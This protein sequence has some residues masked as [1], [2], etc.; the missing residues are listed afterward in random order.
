MAER[1]DEIF[2]RVLPGLR[3]WI[4]EEEAGGC[5][6]PGKAA[7]TVGGEQAS[8]LARGDAHPRSS[9]RRMA[10]KATGLDARISIKR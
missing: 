9:S 7:R 4:V 1:L 5:E 2:A 3:A 8:A 10:K 6:A